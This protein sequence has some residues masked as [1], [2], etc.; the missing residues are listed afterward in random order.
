[1]G[2]GKSHVGRQLSKYLQ[3]PLLDLDYEIERHHNATISAL[4]QTKGEAYFRLLERFTLHQTAFTPTSI[5]ATGGGTPCF[6]NN[7]HWMNKK[8]TCIY[9]DTPVEVLAQRLWKGRHKR[10]LLHGLTQEQLPLFIEQ[11]LAQ[12][13][14]FYEQAEVHFKVQSHDQDMAADLYRQLNYIIGH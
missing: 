5:V 8:G 6:F 14:S 13:R 1:M 11:K 7:I 4:F 9:L 10:P 12:R 3:L 2:A